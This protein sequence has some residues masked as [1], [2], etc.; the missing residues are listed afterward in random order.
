MHMQDDVTSNKSCQRT[1]RRGAGPGMLCTAMTMHDRTSSRGCH[2]AETSLN[3]VTRT[4]L[5]CVADATVADA[6]NPEALSDF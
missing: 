4:S 5:N 1:L 6:R 3:C 2:Q